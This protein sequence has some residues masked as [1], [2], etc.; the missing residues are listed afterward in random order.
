M[1]DADG[2]DD[3]VGPRVLGQDAAR[4]CLERPPG[5]V[6]VIANGHED[7]RGP[8]FVLEHFAQIERSLEPAVHEHHVGTRSAEGRRQ[9]G[10]PVLA[11]DLER[12]MRSGD[13]NEVF[14][15]ESVVAEHCY[16]NRRHAS[17]PRDSS[18]GE[19]NSKPRRD[20]DALYEHVP[21][22]S[23]WLD[24]MAGPSRLGHR[25]SHY[26]Y[27]ISSAFLTAKPA[28]VAILDVPTG[29]RGH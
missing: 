11:N 28:S 6:V 24:R 4:A 21:A 8:G 19:N 12:G 15:E 17:A 18:R 9:D 27:E 7:D 25:V 26:A 22:G 16:T 29:G 20:T 10:P 3:V 1:D 2:L 13:P 14:A 23:I 5:P